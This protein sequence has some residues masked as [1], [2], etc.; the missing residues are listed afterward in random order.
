M[1]YVES[2]NRELIQ[3][4]VLTL[5][6]LSYQTLPALTDLMCSLRDKLI[7]WDHGYQYSEFPRGSNALY[8]APSCAS[9]TSNL[10]SSW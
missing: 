1:S 2:S 6:S 3:M 5:R 9:S 4:K 8:Q 10:C 7:H